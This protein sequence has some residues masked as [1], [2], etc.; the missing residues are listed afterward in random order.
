MA[1]ADVQVFGG[2]ANWMP[3]HAGNRFALVGPEPRRFG[4]VVHDEL[5][6]PF[7][8]FYICSQYSNGVILQWANE[9]YQSRLGVS[10]LKSS[11]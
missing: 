6:S 3:V 9:V 1:L 4:L 7:A 11:T 10:G 2:V 5:A 8:M